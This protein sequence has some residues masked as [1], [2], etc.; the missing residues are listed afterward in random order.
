MG[1]HSAGKRGPFY[2]SL[3]GWFLP[4]LL[5]AVVVAVA[6][7]VLVMTLG[8]EETV[9]PMPAAGESSPAASPSPTET[10]L[11]LES[12]SPT[13]EETKSPRPR[14]TRSEPKKPLIT[15]GI[16][17][18][19]LNSTA[20]TGVDDEVAARLGGLGFRIEAIDDASRAYER[21]I[22]YWSY[23]E[24]QEAAERLARRFSWEVGPKPD[25]LSSTVAIHVVVGV[26]ET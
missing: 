25:N 24:A 3:L 26:D 14:K 22:V 18:Q 6:V 8:G 19:V 23:P 13:P 4:W 9:D 7:W 2:R 1:R 10:E 11:V 20:D 5:I 17:V 21:T 16:N 15:E 12:P